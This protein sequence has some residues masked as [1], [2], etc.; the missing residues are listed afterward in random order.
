VKLKNGKFQ[1]RVGKATPSMFFFSVRKF[2]I[3]SYLEILQPNSSSECYTRTNEELL[4][5]LRAL[6]ANAKTHGS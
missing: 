3:F 6:A 5:K 1:Y 4:N 2:E